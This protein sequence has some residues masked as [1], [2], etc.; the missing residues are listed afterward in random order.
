MVQ[1]DGVNTRWS[2][3][4]CVLNL[5]IAYFD[6]LPIK[7]QHSSMSIRI[8]ESKFF[9]F[10]FPCSYGS[11]DRIKLQY[12]QGKSY[13]HSGSLSNANYK[14]TEVLGLGFPHRWRGAFRNPGSSEYC[15]WLSFLPSLPPFFSIAWTLNSSCDL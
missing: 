10:L 1:Q 6:I 12:T 15:R 4:R 3:G 8:L 5:I 9:F 2:S 14:K 7:R 11:G 13:I